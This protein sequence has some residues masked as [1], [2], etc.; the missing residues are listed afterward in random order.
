MDI[1]KSMRDTFESNLVSAIASEK[2]SLEYHNAFMKIK[3][4]EHAKMKASIEGK[5]KIMAADDD[6]LS[7]ANT[8]KG[9]MD[10]SK[11]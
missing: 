5:E 4:D 8:I 6:A 3:N 2:S 7:T 10:T 1:L 11:G 9:E